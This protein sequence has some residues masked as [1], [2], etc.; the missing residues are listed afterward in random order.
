MSDNSSEEEKEGAVGGGARW[1][2]R[3]VLVAACALVLGVY[4]LSARSGYF[5]LLSSDARDN[6]YNLLV[7]GFRD[8]HLYVKREAPPELARLGAA[9]AGGIQRNPPESLNWDVDGLHDLSYYKGKL[10]LYFGVTPALL[11]FW[12]CLALTGHCA[13]H[14]AAVVI[15]FSVGFLAGAGL[16]CA[17]RRRFFKEAGIGAVAAGT[18]ALGLA[19]FAPAIL[20]ECDVYE[21]AISC[22]YALTLLALAGVWA[23]LQD[24]PGRWRWLAA[25]SLAYGLAL[26]ARPS[27][28]FGAVILLVPVAREWREKRPLWPLLA[29]ATAPIAA[30]GLGLMAY[31]ALRFDNPLEFGQRFQLPVTPHQQFNPRFLWFNFVVGFLEPAR[32]GGSFPFVHEITPPAQPEGYFQTHFPFGVLTN[33]PLVWLALAAPLAWWRRS[34]G[35]RSILRWF[36]AAV[37][38][39]FV[40][41]ALTL[42]LHD[43]MCL[44]YEVEYASPLVLLAV[45]GFFALERALAGRPAWR[46]AA[47][48]G[49]GLLLAFSVAFNLLAGVHSQAQLLCAVGNAFLQKGRLDEAIT[50]Y[51]KAL[52]IAPDY[53]E[54]WYDLG[55]ALDQMGRLDEA[56][57]HYR[58]AVQ[59][60]PPFPYAYNNL[61]NALM[62][63]GKADEAIAQYQT[64]LTFQPDFTLALFNLGN[65]LLQKGGLDEAIAQYQKVLQLKPDHPQAHNNL[66]TALLQEGK[67]DEAIT[68]YQAALQLN[69]DS[70]DAR[71]SLGDAL[72]QKHDWEG[73]VA[74]YLQALKINP[75]SG[76]VYANLGAA[77]FQTGRTQEAIAS[78]QH[79]LE[80]NPDQAATLINLA[81]SLATTPDDSLRDGPKAAALASRANQ[82]SGGANPMAL[83]ALA[84]AYAAEGRYEPAAS[85]ARRALDLAVAQKNDA[86]AASLREDAKHHE[87]GAPLWKTPP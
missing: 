68:Q 75:K 45:I 52:K 84:A 37:A 33:V 6:Y 77:L 36:L 26:G 61:G 73:A 35:A 56:I 51:D 48:W 74:S 30:I 46:R 31:N 40:G 9:A 59:L 1:T 19:N 70:A 7:R 58:K 64:A 15:F 34:G 57:T 53:A 3:V 47:R 18:L 49:W 38:L 27:L 50:Q 44:R 8:G 4:A 81:W 14:K 28:L 55:L 16:L 2:R 80:I 21:V 79:S 41:S 69:P 25:A 83:R 82:L 24:A 23:A 67:V 66:G 85:T 78:W 87:A 29:A 22:G 42:G 54:A 63:K 76:D 86:L 60:N 11:L 17:I 71:H 43:S 32:W 10:Y 65:A 13:P 39:L 12:P 62:Q 20:R 72:L 5:D